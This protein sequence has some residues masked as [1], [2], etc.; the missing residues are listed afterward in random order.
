MT[1][2]T[3]SDAAVV[4]VEPK[5]LRIA[6]VST[7]DELCGIAGYTRA[8]EIQLAGLADIKVFDL[9][10]YLLRSTHKRVIKLGD[11]HVREIAAELRGFDSVNIQLEHGTLGRTPWQIMR[12]L[13]MLVDAAPCLSVTFHTILSDDPVPWERIWRF[14]SRGNLTGAFRAAGD[15]KRAHILSRGVYKMLRKR[16]SRVPTRVIVHT[17]RD[18]RLLRD[19]HRLAEVHHHPLSFVDP[20][21][22][23][24]IRAQTSRADFPTLRDLPPNVKLVGTF[25]FLSPYKGFETAVEALRYLPDDYHLLIFGGIHPQTIKREQPLDPY[26]AKLLK[27]AKIGTTLMDDFSA[28]GTSVSVSGDEGAT[29]LFDHHPQDLQKRMHFMGVLN[30]DGFTSAMAICDT[31]VFPYLEVGQSSSGPISIAMDMNC[32][33]LAARTGAFLQYARYHPGK[34]EMFD[35]GNYAELASRIVAPPAEAGDGILSYDTESNARLYMEVNTPPPR[36][37]LLGRRS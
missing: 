24:E 1:S 17:K 34:F 35:I 3:A 10:Q 19:V 13:K 4:G 12:R 6:I 7:Y 8:V 29:K 18:M 16:Q 23:A 9:D 36:R 2:T 30:D 33:I 32:R 25:G 15:N 28:G 20:A 21:R 26:I 37:R 22:A 14:A 11:K 5:R 31:V 27:S